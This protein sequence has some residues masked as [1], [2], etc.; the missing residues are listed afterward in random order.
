MTLHYFYLC[1]SSEFLTCIS[2]K[3]NILIDQF[4]KAIKFIIRISP[5]LFLTKWFINKFYPDELPL[6]YLSLR[7]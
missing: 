4:I 1:F 3:T 7:I 6:F 2:D 5:I